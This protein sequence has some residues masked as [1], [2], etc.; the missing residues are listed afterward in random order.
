[1]NNSIT[2]YHNLVDTPCIYSSN[3]LSEV[4][5]WINSIFND[6]PSSSP[7]E[8]T[9]TEQIQGNSKE[10]YSSEQ[11]NE[12]NLFE[13]FINTSFADNANLTSSV[14][15]PPISNFGSI[16]T[17]LLQINRKRKSSKT[18][19]TVNKKSRKQKW[20]PREKNLFLKE[21]KANSLPY[22]W[23]AISKKIKN[24]HSEFLKTHYD[25]SIFYQDN[26]DPAIDASPFKVSE[27]DMICDELNL[28]NWNFTLITSKLN[29][30]TSSRR[31]KQKVSTFVNNHVIRNFQ[32]KNRNYLSQNYKFYTLIDKNAF[33]SKSTKHSIGFEKKD[34]KE[35]SPPLDLT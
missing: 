13:K 18:P 17:D 1:M 14:I 2:Q 33:Y 8:K 10:D 20:T 6:D 23:K 11:V 15:Y 21:L 25:C 26:L 31:T 12:E 4:D 28:G 22:D 16:T 35:K 3:P 7:N 30:Q 27:I 34:L 9:A 24:E 29:D 32:N 5:D 19:Q